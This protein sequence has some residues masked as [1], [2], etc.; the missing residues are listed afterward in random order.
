MTILATANELHTAGITVIPTNG[1]R[2]TISWKHYQTNPNTS[3]E[4]TTWFTNPT[5]GLA[6]VTGK[7]SGN[8]EMAEIEGKALTHLPDI[9]T[10]ANDTGLIDL[11]TKAT[12]GWAE[13]SPSGGIHWI[14]RLQGTPVPGNTPLARRHNPQTGR[15]ETLTETRGQGGYFI[16]APTNG[17]HHTTGNPWKRITGGP[18]TIPTLT[19]EER[20]AFHALLAS[21]GEDDPTGAHTT[22]DTPLPLTDPNNDWTEGN[23]PGDH[24]EAETSWAEILEPHGWK[25]ARTTGHTTYWLRPGKEFGQE[26]SAT[27]GRDTARDRLYVFSTSTPFTPETPYTKFGA[28]ALLNHDSDHQAAA[29]ALAK[30]GWGKEPH[31]DLGTIFKAGKTPN[32]TKEPEQPT[33]TPAQTPLDHDGDFQPLA[34]SDYG[35]ALRLIAAHGNTIRYNYDRGR[36]YHF[37]QG[38]WAQQPKSGGAVRE[39]VK[40]IA[41]RLPENDQPD[42]EWKKR[43]LSA[44]GT[45][46]TLTQAETD[47]HLAVPADAFDNHPWEI[48]T[49]GGIVN[50]KT[51]QLEPHNPERMHTKLTKY[52]PNPNADQ[53]VWQTFLNQTFPNDPQMIGYIKRLAGYSIIGKV[54]EHI[55]PFAYGSGGNGKS[56]FMDTIAGVLGDY[57]ASAPN[58][59]LM[60]RKYQQHS[61][62]IARLTGQRWV[63]CHEVNEHDKFDEAKVKLLTGGDRLTARFM[64]QDD[65]EFTPTHHLW[66]TGNFWPTVE[67]GG[68]GFWRRL[69]IIPFTHTVPPEERIPDLQGILLR[70]HGEAIMTWLVEGAVEY[71]KDGLQEPESV[72]AATRTYEESQD[73]VSRFLEDEATLYPG[74]PNCKSTVSDVRREY[75]AWCRVEGEEP[76]KGRAFTRQLERAGVLVGRNAPK[77]TKGARMF[78]GIKLNSQ[79]EKEEADKKRTDLFGN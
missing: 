30:E 31:I 45:T 40:N 6:I 63:N 23:R 75:E 49:P 9:I 68:D 41:S 24:Y 57:A 29:K 36:W 50:L 61:T 28:Y 44:V 22:G 21:I 52:S 66:L 27:T 20:T 55:L 78:G 5:T 25:K 54:R 69:R 12:T 67:S 60:A 48:N 18:A 16:A 8:L 35:N 3:S 42:K 11:W 53:T 79:I 1:K 59:F 62:E 76:L 4:L 17:T 47:P 10:L 73:T 58:E 32:P 7:S 77:G 38:H 13:Q 51:G 43:S 33:Q 64:R 15:T 72:L 14:Y 65:F 56:V 2:P 71:L 39:A 26:I 37:N 70:E 46:N 19:P 34:R 74:N